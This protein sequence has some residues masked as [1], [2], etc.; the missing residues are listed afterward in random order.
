MRLDNVTTLNR[1]SGRSIET[2]RIPEM[3]RRERTRSSIC[4][5]AAVS[6]W[7]VLV[8]FSVRGSAQTVPSSQEPRAAEGATAGPAFPAW[9]SFADELHRLGDQMIAGAAGSRPVVARSGGS[10][11]NRGHQCRWRSSG[12]FALVEH[13][14]QRLSAQCRHHLPKSRHYSGR[15]LSSAWRSRFPSHLQPGSIR[16][17]TRE[18]QYWD[19]GADL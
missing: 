17:H 19:R 1:K 6:W 13:H 3:H 7:S 16:P 15:G 18:R 14:A 9:D 8:L 5:I 10:E 2:E 12:I 11:V 4:R